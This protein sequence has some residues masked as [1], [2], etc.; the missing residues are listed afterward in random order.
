[1]SMFFNDNDNGNNGNGNDSETTF[2]D[3]FVDDRDQQAT[4]D[5]G[6]D[7]GATAGR[8]E[9]ESQLAGSEAFVDDGV[10]TGAGLDSGTDTQQTGLGVVEET[11]GG[12]QV[13]LTGS[14]A[15][16]AVGGEWLQK[17]CEPGDADCHGSA[18]N[19]AASVGEQAV[20]NT[21]SEV[22]S[23]L[24]QNIEAASAAGVIEP[25]SPNGDEEHAPRDLFP[26][27]S[28]P[29]P[30]AERDP[31]TDLMRTA[32]TRDVSITP[33]EAQHD[34]GL[35]TRDVNGRKRGVDLAEPSDV[36][37]R[38][39][40]IIADHLA[41]T[42]SEVEQKRN[43]PAV[44]EIAV[45]DELVDVGLQAARFGERRAEGLDSRTLRTVRAQFAEGRDSGAVTLTR[46]QYEELSDAIA[47]FGMETSPAQRPERLD[48]LESTVF[49][50]GEDTAQSGG[51]GTGT[52]E[53]TP[54]TPVEQVEFGS[55]DDARAFRDQHDGVIADADVPQ[56]KTVTIDASD[57]EI[58]DRAQEQALV[59][60]ADERSETAEM[61]PLSDGEI[62]NLRA[63]HD[64]FSWQQHGFQ[65]MRAKAAL[66]SR[67]AAGTDWM[68]YF[69]PGEDWTSS[70]EKL[71]EGKQRAARGGGRTA[72]EH[73]M[74][75]DSP[76]EELSRGQIARRIEAARGRGERHAIEGARE[77]HKGALEALQTDFGWSSAEAKRLQEMVEDPST[78]FTS[79]DVKRI[80]SFERSAT[81]GQ[82]V[83]VPTR[84][85]PH[86]PGHRSRTSGR[87][88]PP[89]KR[90]MP[91]GIVRSRRT[92]RFRPGGE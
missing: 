8:T 63:S 46:S 71:E 1:M 13:D 72:L 60:F 66:Q 7:A 26:G 82:M 34:V 38:E 86:P 56:A 42:A 64:T 73:G 17:D 87:F 19:W 6:L 55:I 68:D 49:T 58:V 25:E 18:S 69:D 15:S 5:V 12:G 50:I 40:A 91:P 88:S 92:G 75:T 61:E 84:R 20:E 24:E 41:K 79:A 21:G 16:E 89:A 39:E 70:L 2:E 30:D 78:P 23:E 54:T 67:G 90:R 9:R 81:S 11:V 74:R 27:H 51:S 77:G 43:K 44:A 35:A 36:R 45:D 47:E 52:L 80:E 14:T 28:Q 37:Q 48:D 76:D 4:L 83:A 85:T 53:S 22:R 31:G 32:A 29:L 59:S 10:G 3:A 65:A 33:G 62:A 57:S